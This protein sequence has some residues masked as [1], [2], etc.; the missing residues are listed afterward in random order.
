MPT[1][2]RAGRQL[3]S[4]I[5]RSSIA[6]EVEAELDFHVEM[7]TRELVA[8]GMDYDTARADAIR[9][10]GDIRAVSST[11]RSIGVRRERDMQRAEYLAELRQDLRYTVRQLTK[12]LS[13]TVVAV[14]T[15]ALGIGATTTIFSALQSVVLRRFPF[16]HPSA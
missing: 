11:C 12:S 2:G 14:L 8:K 1:L 5:W 3:K 15:L 16:A 10:F 6:E 7:L 9:R 13:F 4:L